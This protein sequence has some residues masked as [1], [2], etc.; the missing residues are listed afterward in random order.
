M[1]IFFL[2][3]NK[4][5]NKGTCSCQEWHYIE[6]SYIIYQSWHLKV[7]ISIQLRYAILGACIDWFKMWLTNALSDTYYCQEWYSQAA[8]HQ[9]QLIVT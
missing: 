4:V 2:Y 1:V 5:S 9:V 3:V 8:S 6:A 7:L